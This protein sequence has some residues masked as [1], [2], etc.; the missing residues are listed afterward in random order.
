MNILSIL[1][2]I[3]SPAIAALLILSPVFPNNEIKIRRFAKTFGI[4]HFIYS[5]LFLLFF[6]PTNFGWSYQKELT[7]LN[8][9]WLKTLGVTA[10]FGM[11][12]ISLVF[13]LLTSFLIM[14]A[15]VASK[16]MIRTK[17]RIYYSLV[18]VLET[19]FLGVFCAKDIFLFLLFWELQL[20]PIYFL[21][22]QW[23]DK[24]SSYSAMKYV[25]Y[26]FVASMFMFLGMLVLYF[27]SFSIS[28]VLTGDIE[29]LSMSES[30]F[31]LWFQAFIFF[32]LLLGFAVKIPIIPFHTAVAKAQVEAVTPVS[33]LMAGVLPVIGGYG[34]IRFNM[35][36]FPEVFNYFAPILIIFGVVNIIYGACLALA[37]TDIKKITAYAGFV[38][39]GFALI[40]LGALTELGFNGAVFQL[41]IA[42][43]IIS[44]LFMVTG[45]VYLRTKTREVSALG[46]LSQVMPICMCLGFIICFGAVGVPFT[47][48]FIAKFMNLS[49]LILS[50]IEP[51]KFIVSMAV[52]SAIGLVLNACYI[53]YL[54]HKTFF[55]SVLSQ[56]KAESVQYDEDGNE[57]TVVYPKRGITKSEIIVLS[58]L[59]IAIILFGIFP[60]ALLDIF[61]VT[62]D[63]ILDF[64]KV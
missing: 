14:I 15:L 60:N 34:I 36:L 27:Y 49:G 52:V 43:L 24:T 28:G 39:T 25:V 54:F 29:S 8:T 7:F 62:S 12:G 64:M 47:A 53:L 16:S 35:G 2:L 18:L 9:S 19:A 41:V 63:V 40:G 21:V 56:F 30:V 13:V 61:Q 37:Q 50:D 1:A 38:Q 20:I 6:N 22:S 46:G 17:H 59:G 31:A 42:G 5:M 51:Q 11:D 3:F 10:T 4:L 44:G 23:G 58:L 57:I 45:V 48:G 55:G 26:T 32:C 33:M